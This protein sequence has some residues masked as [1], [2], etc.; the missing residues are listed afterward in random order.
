MSLRGCDVTQGV[1]VSDE[2]LR[3]T[4]LQLEEGPNQQG[5]EPVDLLGKTVT[6]FSCYEIHDLI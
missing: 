1:V 5:E 2:E 3:R 6:L 4:F